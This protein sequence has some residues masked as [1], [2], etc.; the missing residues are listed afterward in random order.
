MCIR[1][2]LC[3]PLLLYI[4]TNTIYNVCIVKYDTNVYVLYMIFILDGYSYNV[5]HLCKKRYCFKQISYLAIALD[6]N[7]CLMSDQI[8]VSFYQY[9]VH[10]VNIVL[11]IRIMY[12]T[13]EN[14]KNRYVQ[15]LYIIYFSFYLP[16]LLSESEVNAYY[17]TNAVK[18]FCANY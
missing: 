13:K 7:I 17:I 10:I 4:L 5:A 9:M 15:H 8:I 2:I 6:L 12:C 14:Q 3:F 11:Y 16:K 18:K 1:Y